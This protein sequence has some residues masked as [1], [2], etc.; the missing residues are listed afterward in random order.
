MHD[1]IN[2]GDRRVLICSHVLVFIKQPTTV[3]T[4]LFFVGSPSRCCRKSVKFCNFCS[5]N[6]LWATNLV[7][8]QRYPQELN[9]HQ[10]R[11][12]VVLN[13]V[14][15]NGKYFIT[16][17]TSIV[18]LMF[19]LE[20]FCNFKDQVWIYVGKYSKHCVWSQGDRVEEN[21]TYENL[22]NCYHQTIATKALDNSTR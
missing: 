16:Y 3:S 12:I 11:S 1:G 2:V 5:V 8:Q 18:Q 15:L 13:S 22:V 10:L 7:Q 17:G 6:Q 19:L 20:I 14:Y 21:T 9:L 4:G